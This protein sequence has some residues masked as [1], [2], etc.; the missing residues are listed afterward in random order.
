MSPDEYEQD[1][2]LFNAICNHEKKLVISHEGDPVWRN[3]V[4]SGTPS[5]LAL[6]YLKFTFNFVGRVFNGCFF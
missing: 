1:E 3:A 2:L 5:L 6:R 4:L